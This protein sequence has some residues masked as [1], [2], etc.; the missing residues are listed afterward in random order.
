MQLADYL[1]QHGI[2]RTEFARE[3]GVSPQTITGWCD[4]TF[5]PGKENAKRVVEA[6]AGAVTPNDFMQSQA[7]E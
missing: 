5:W 6:T 2:K 3:I 1:N 4:G 7:A